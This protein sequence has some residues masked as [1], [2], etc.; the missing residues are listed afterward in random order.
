ML[1]LINA[2]RRQAL[3]EKPLQPLILSPALSRVAR[4]YAEDMVKRRFYGHV[5]PEGRKMPYRLGLA[6]VTTG[7]RGEN[8]AG[9]YQSP[10]AAETAFMSE[11]P[12]NPD[13][14]RGNILNP[15][16]NYVGIGIARD[17]DG[18]LMIV[19]QFSA[20]APHENY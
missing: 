2:D 9:G 18:M 8:L 14:H 1:L 11:P 17:K 20:A 12:D 7:A 4:Q 19:Q 13:N 3:P 5:D 6:G 10:D 15:H 16:Y